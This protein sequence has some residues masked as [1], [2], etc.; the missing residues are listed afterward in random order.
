MPTQ[1]QISLSPISAKG[2]TFSFDGSS[3]IRV[4]VGTNGQ[5][6]T[7]VS[8][9][10]SGLAWSTLG[11]VSSGGLQL[12]SSSTLTADG[13][14]SF[15]NIPTGTGSY[16]AL[17]IFGYARS[18]IASDVTS[19]SL[20]LG[21]IANGYNFASVTLAA[22]GSATKDVNQSTG[23]F[24]E[25]NGASA[26][27][28]YFTP[29]EIVI[30]GQ[31]SHRYLTTSNNGGVWLARSMVQYTGSAAATVKNV[32]GSMYDSSEYSRIDLYGG[33]L[34]T[35]TFASGSSFHLYGYRRFGA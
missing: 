2:D 23:I 25:I 6:L 20:R 28:S 1:S 9:A 3:R 24:A 10:G 32:G 12:I 31:M 11:S 8:S 21:A 26:S 29:F 18:T 7:A 14:V 15:I 13:T 19:A 35:D 4:P 27:A 16:V 22:V 17:H 30:S 5:I 34:T 33:L